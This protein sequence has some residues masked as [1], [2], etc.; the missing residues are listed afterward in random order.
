MC[1]I[2]QKINTKITRIQEN[3]EQL[4]ELG[5]YINKLSLLSYK[6]FRQET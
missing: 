6:I 4:N 1:K 3:N 2:Y 5:N